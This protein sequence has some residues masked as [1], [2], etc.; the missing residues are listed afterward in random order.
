MIFKGSVF[1]LAVMI[2]S[3][4]SLLSEKP[5]GTYRLQD[6]RVLQQQQQWYFEGRL[7]LADEKDSFSASVSW[8]HQSGRDDIE[9]SG[10]L[11]QG[12]LLITVEADFVV[13]D[14]GDNHKEF[15]GPAEEVL[16]EQLGVMIPVNALRHW[17]LGMP[18]PEQSFV[19]QVDGFFQAG[20]RVGFREMQ[21]VNALVLPRKINA[22]K[23][24]TRIKLI[25]D[26]WDLS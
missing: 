24:K 5:E 8:R 22:E 18:D 26:Q 15:R 2:L 21:Q 4:C 10:P 7:A 19:E 17:V 25:V 12:K 16:A 13:L 1:L 23:D 11:A 20:W 9:L 14:D 6:M 3:G